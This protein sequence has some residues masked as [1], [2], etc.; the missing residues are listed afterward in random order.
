MQKCFCQYIDENKLI[1]HLSKRKSRENL[2]KRLVKLIKAALLVLLAVNSHSQGIS[3]NAVTCS[4][5]AI[6]IIFLVDVS[7]VNDTA[8]AIQQHR[9]LRTLRHIDLLTT[10]RP[11]KFGLIQF[12]RTAETLL[13]LGSPF[14]SDTT[15]LTNL[16]SSLHPN[17]Q[18]ETSV[19]RA[20]ENTAEQFSLYSEERA[21]RVVLLAHDGVNTDLVAETLEAVLVISCAFFPLLKYYYINKGSVYQLRSTIEQMNVEVFALSGNAR[22][23]A[24]ALLGYT[25]DRSRLYL[26]VDDNKTFQDMLDEVLASCSQPSPNL[27]TSSSTPR[28]AFGIRAQRAENSKT[29]VFHP[30][31]AC[32]YDRADVLIVLDTSGSVFRVFED[33][34]KIAVALLQE[35]P[36]SSFA[37]SI[38][39]GVVRFAADADVIL[40]LVKARAKEEIIN[41]VKGVKFTGQNTR[42][43]GAVEIAV[44]EMERARRKDAKQ[45]VILISDGHGQEYWNVVQATGKRLQETG[46]ELFAVSASRDYNEAEL[47]IY[48]G[49][50]SRVFVGPK[51][52]G[53]MPIVSAYLRSCVSKGDKSIITITPKHTKKLATNSSSNK[54]NLELE[55]S[56]EG[57]G[58]EKEEG[59]G[60]EGVF[61]GDGDVA[62]LEAELSSI[63]KEV[64]ATEKKGETK[65]RDITQPGAS[66]CEVD[67]VL[68]IDRSQSVEDDFNKQIAVREMEY[69]KYD[70][71]VELH[72]QSGQ[73][74]NI[75]SAIERIEH[76]G[77]TTSTVSGAELAIARLL[78]NRRP[79]ARLVT[80]LFSDGHSQDYWQHLIETSMLVFDLKKCHFILIIVK[81]L[82]ISKIFYS[83]PTLGGYEIHQIVS[84]SPLLQATISQ[85]L[86]SSIGKK[87]TLEM[88]NK[89]SKSEADKAKEHTDDGGSLLTRQS[90]KPELSTSKTVDLDTTTT[91]GL[92]VTEELDTEDGGSDL[93]MSTVIPSEDIRVHGIRTASDVRKI[94]EGAESKNVGCK[95]DILFV[96]DTSTSVEADFQ[97]QLQFAVDLVKRLPSDDFERR[98][99]IGAIV[100]HSKANL[101][102]SLDQSSSRS[103]VLDS[104][105]AIHH[106]GGSTSVASGVSLAVD[107]LERT[108]REGVRQM[109]ILLSD[110]N[111]Q[112]HWDDVIRQSNRLRSTGTEVYAV[113]VSKKYMFRELELYAGDK[114][115]VYI[116]ARTRQFLDEVERRATQCGRTS[117]EGEAPS[118]HIVSTDSPRFSC[119]SD[120]VDMVLVLD[121]STSVVDEFYREKQFASDLIQA[122]P[123]TIFQDRLRVGLVS[124]SERALAS[125]ELGAAQS[126]RDI[127]FELDR[128]SHTEN[129]T[130]IVAATEEVLKEVAARHRPSARLIVV[131][132][133]DGNSQDK[134]ETTQTSAASLLATGADIF[135]VTLSEKYNLDELK[136]YTGNERHLYVGNRTD[137]FIQ[138][139]SAL[140][141]SCDEQTSSRDE[142]LKSHKEL[143]EIDKL[144]K[145]R[146]E[147]NRIVNEGEHLRKKK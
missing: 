89:E 123:D 79:S 47:L 140:L 39:V 61:R 107:E 135:A 75:V 108:R 11:R 34:R 4:S 64:E 71:K 119:S 33:Q 78:T 110:G 9:L 103:S 130:S 142:S 22:P 67:L 113:T 76:T 98:V 115:H 145:F 41:T 102:M 63:Q 32:G 19:A 68:I 69:Y 138:D 95:V 6:E 35:I 128:I 18:L 44:D 80:L 109:V 134:K 53:F 88:E 13:E 5:S 143:E 133:S 54:H 105:L 28:R 51:Y 40:P 84:C 94:S 137:S 92:N 37:E 136:E 139:M 117:A 59:S 56:G 72:L 60:T 101:T 55:G 106:S 52:S 118:S 24:F 8:F 73:R 83:L 12:H 17:R 66:T 70:A 26:D 122:L 29:R 14:A 25:G 62:I 45:I 74:E 147:S 27:S 3:D 112:D 21:S 120:P 114:F 46:A 58:E 141:S 48:V 91:I 129:I 96:I 144:V 43:A 10:G 127:L 97:L 146:D 20:L 36:N 30:G 49:D 65:L 87:E 2:A 86:S 121:T 90:E 100:F 42:I 38:Q 57:S 81:L 104:L 124:F 77:G 116:D 1:Y 7:A 23:N 111:S 93:S 15:R 82:N 125:V 31:Q 131:I 126:K 16:I 85:K 50:R 132:V 99:R